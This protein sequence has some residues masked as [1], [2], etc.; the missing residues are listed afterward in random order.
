MT[1]DALEDGQIRV[2][3]G[4]PDGGHDEHEDFDPLD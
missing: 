4:T 1:I 2:Y 3:W